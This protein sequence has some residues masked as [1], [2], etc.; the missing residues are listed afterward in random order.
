MNKKEIIRCLQACLNECADHQW[1][2]K[3]KN[4]VVK[5]FDDTFRFD[6]GTTQGHI[7]IIGKPE[8]TAYVVF[9]GSKDEQ[10][11]AD[12]CGATGN[13]NFLKVAP[14]ADNCEITKKIKTKIKVHRGNLNAYKTVKDNIFKILFDIQPS[15]VYGTGHSKG[16]SLAELFCENIGFHVHKNNKF[17]LYKK[18]LSI[19]YVGSAGNR[20]GNQAFINSLLENINEHI[21]LWVGEDPVPKVPWPI[22][23]YRHPPNCKRLNN[24]EAIFPLTLLRFINPIGW[25][26]DHYPDLI[27]KMAKKQL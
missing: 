14:Y 17:K 4:K 24:T 21:K 7:G 23:G 16:C 22:F 19:T 27:L 6:K 2:Q 1:Y 15:I 8:K 11:N 20:T 13:F 5:V 10:G 3:R 25:P 12:W 18:I 26:F 9:E